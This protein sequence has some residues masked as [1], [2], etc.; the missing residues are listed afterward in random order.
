M[1]PSRVSV[2][3]RHIAAGISN[4]STSVRR[5][6]V[7][8][9]LRRI[10]AAMD[11]PKV[12]VTKVELESL[13][14]DGEGTFNIWG[15]MEFS[16]VYSQGFFGHGVPEWKPDPG[17]DPSEDPDSFYFMQKSIYESEV[18]KEAEKQA[19]GGERPSGPGPGPGPGPGTSM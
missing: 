6:P 10:L 2:R 12:M 13:D 3:L 16:G 18:F 9:D 5:D 7:R 11:A 15:T 14:S 8:R 19:A 1:K 4:C 17:P